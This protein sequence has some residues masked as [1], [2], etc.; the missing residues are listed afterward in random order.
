M[1]ARYR[2]CSALIHGYVGL[3]A[4]CRQNVLGL[5]QAAMQLDLSGFG[6]GAFGASAVTIL[7]HVLKLLLKRLNSCRAACGRRRASRDDGSLAQRAEVTMGRAD[8][9]PLWPGGRR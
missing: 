5:H 3:G 6:F 1:T 2:G 4:K 8:A 7:C 9:R